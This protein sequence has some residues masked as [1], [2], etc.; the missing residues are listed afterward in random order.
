MP[1]RWPCWWQGVIPDATSTTVVG[2]S[3]H[4]DQRNRPYGIGRPSPS[5]RV[6]IGQRARFEVVFVKVRGRVYAEPF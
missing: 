3:H 6:D 4:P 2:K 1:R 5:P